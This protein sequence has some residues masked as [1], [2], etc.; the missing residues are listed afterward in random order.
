MVAD[1]TDRGFKHAVRAGV[2][3]H[4]C[5]DSRPVGCEVVLKILGIDIA[6]G[7]T[8]DG[9]NLQTGHHRAGRVGAVSTHGNEAKIAMR[10][11][12]RRVV[13]TDCKEAS[14]LALRSRVWFERY[15]CEA[16]DLRKPALELGGHLR[17]SQRLSRR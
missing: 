7:E 11:V 4:T 15:R 8:F 1:L 3:H 2:R 12:A 6:V 13:A 14:V 17:V 9:D 10:F 16:G 5:G